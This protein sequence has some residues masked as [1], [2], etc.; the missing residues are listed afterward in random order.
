MSL[1]VW[2]PLN[3][4]LINQGLDGQVL[5]NSNVTL[6]ATNGKIGAYCASFNGSS[7]RLSATYT[8]PVPLTQG[9]L[10]CWAKFNSFPAS[11]AYGTIIRYGNTTGYQNCR[12]GL[13]LE[14]TNRINVIINGSTVGQ[15]IYTHSLSTGVWYHLCATFDG[16][17]VKLYLNGEQVLS[18]TA[19]K[20]SA[21][22]DVSQLD[23]GGTNA[24]FLNG[25][26]NDVRIYDHALSVKEVEELAKGLMIHYKLD[27][28]G[29]GNP[30]LLM[31]SNVG[32]LTKVRASYDRYFES[33]GNGSYT[34]TFEAINDAP[35]P[36]I[37][38][39]VHYVVSTAASFHS[40]VWYNG[41]TVTVSA[42]PYTMSC[43][44]KRISSGNLGFRF[45]YGKSPYVA[46]D[47]VIATDYEWHQYSWTFTPNTASGGA[48]SGGSTRI[49]VG[50]PTTVGEIL[51]C[52]WKLE[53]GSMATP[54]CEYGETFGGVYDVSGYNRNGTANALTFSS[55]T[56]RYSVNSVFNGTNS[57]IKTEDVSWMIQGADAITINVWAKTSSW[58]ASTRIFSCTEAGGF[59][60][61]QDTTNSGY[62]RFIMDV[63]TNEA[64]SSR[65]Y[66]ICASAFKVS[67]LPTNEWVMLTCRATK[68]ALN[69]YVNGVQQ[70]IVSITSYGIHYNTSAR[71]FLGCE[72]NVANPASPYFNG[73][74]SD[75]RIYATALTDNQIKA[76]YNESAA[77][78]RAGALFARE[79]V[80]E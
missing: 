59:N 61:E 36:G 13:Y 34:A 48:A 46:Q 10:A 30:N 78:D 11:N 20:G 39:G 32:S 37:K 12:L 69:T 64:Q 21:T 9:T 23:I 68:T 65:A 72:A 6:N 28:C 54:W 62:Y 53:V 19:T 56:P 77:I 76:L 41:G 25:Y 52:G 42:Q 29:I 38:Y 33:S 8:T 16:T 3:G 4:E 17:I 26:L 35:A 18:K 58:P 45:Q 74:M 14:Y 60:I 75:F 22:A 66:A 40:V 55:N 67:D 7:S 49:Y 44:V 63:Y 50:G 79:F 47:Y 73:Q 1:Q 70:Q 5:T 57:Y 80:E 51:V 71:L 24:S 43:Y 27:N 15:N 31:D 2:L